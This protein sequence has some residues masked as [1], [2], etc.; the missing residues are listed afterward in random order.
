MFT[1]QQ[2]YIIKNSHVPVLAN[3]QNG[4]F[5]FKD[6]Y[7]LEFIVKQD[8]E[9]M[10]KINT[11]C[12]PFDFN[13]GIQY[14]ISKQRSVYDNFV[15]RLF[16]LAGSDIIKNEFKDQDDF[17]AITLCNDD[18]QKTTIQYFEVNHNFRHSYEPKQKYR[19]VGT[20]ALNALKEIYQS[21]ELFGQS[22]SHAIDFWLKNGFTRIKTHDL[23]IHWCQR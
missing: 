21:N 23:Y 10:K 6:C 1:A 3:Q 22:A 2:D 17:L 12:M 9:T 4:R 19:N 14:K 16:L 11:I 18:E 5:E 15:Y 13:T 7:F 20:S 8:N